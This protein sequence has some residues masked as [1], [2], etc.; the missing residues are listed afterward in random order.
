MNHPKKA[1]PND[2]QPPAP[3]NNLGDEQQPEPK[4]VAIYARYS[5]DRQRPTSIDQIRECRDAAASNGWVFSEKK[6]PALDED[7]PRK[8]RGQKRRQP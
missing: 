1:I 5:C 7:Q 6:S 8:A 2:P 3:T 4:R